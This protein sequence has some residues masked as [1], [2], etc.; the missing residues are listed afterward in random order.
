MEAETN[1]ELVHNGR[2]IVITT[3]GKPHPEKRALAASPAPARPK[4]AIDGESIPVQYDPGTK[5]YIAISHSPYL[6]H[7]TLIDLAKHVADHAIAK[8]SP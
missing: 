1:Q 7:D 5:Q 8:R 2:K 3:E 6:S 4:V